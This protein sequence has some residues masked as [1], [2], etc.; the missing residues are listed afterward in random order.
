[1]ASRF[2]VVMLAIVFQ[3]FTKVSARLITR[4]PGETTPEYP[5][6]VLGP[7]GSDPATIEYQLN[8]VA[9]NVRDLPRSLEFYT[10]VFGMRLIT[11]ARITEHFSASYLGYS[12]A[13]KN[14]TG[15]MTSEELMRQQRNS[16]GLLELL[17]FE[18]INSTDVPVSTE[19][20]NTFSHIGFIVPD[21][22]AIQRRLESYNVTIY[23]RV[24]EPTPEDGPFNRATMLIR[25]MIEPEE[26]ASI[27]ATLS[28][29]QKSYI[30]AANPDG[31]LIE[32]MPL[33]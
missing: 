24:D 20:T 26:F 29:A 2:V 18:S 19:H 30:F 6:L 10:R 14:G 13:G 7:E 1:M 5:Q 3:A 16:Q 33:E 31:N 27:H 9:L 32:V 11:T 17:R 15:Y 4:V 28:D 12:H 8:H 23:K 25:D 21:T 22:M